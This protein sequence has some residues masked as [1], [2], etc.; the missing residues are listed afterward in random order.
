M[1][2]MLHPRRACPLCGRTDTAFPLFWS[3]CVDCTAKLRPRDVI[4]GVALD[5]RP[6]AADEWRLVDDD[7]LELGRARRNEPIIVREHAPTLWAEFGW[8]ATT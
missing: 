1:S 6:L 4:V 5:P 2:P 8:Q 7:G 3:F